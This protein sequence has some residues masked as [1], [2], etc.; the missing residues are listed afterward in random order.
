MLTKSATFKTFAKACYYS[1]V[2]KKNTIV[3]PVQIP[4]SVA[5]I[6]IL[7]FGALSFLSHSFWPGVET[8]GWGYIVLTGSFGLPLL[9]LSASPSG[10]RFGQYIGVLTGGIASTL[11]LLQTSMVEQIVKEL[12]AETAIS[13]QSAVAFLGVFI[14]SVTIPIAA[15]IVSRWSRLQKMVVCCLVC[16]AFAIA[17]QQLWFLLAKLSP[18]ATG[19]ELWTVA[20][21]LIH[22][23]TGAVFGLLLGAF[24]AYSTKEAS[25]RSGIF[26]FRSIRFRPGTIASAVVVLT[27]ASVLGIGRVSAQVA[28]RNRFASR[29]VDE[30]FLALSNVH[31]ARSQ[32]LL[33]QE[34]ETELNNA[35]TALANS[36]GFD[37][38]LRRLLSMVLPA[39]E[40]ESSGRKATAVFKKRV[41]ALNKYMAKEKIPFFFEPHEI[42]SITGKRRFLLRFKVEDVRYVTQGNRQV[43]M[44][45]MRRMDQILY[46]TPFAGLSYQG[47]GTIQMDHVDA[48]ALRFHARAFSYSNANGRNYARTHCSRSNDPFCETRGLMYGDMAQALKEGLAKKGIEDDAL[49]S[50]LAILSQKWKHRTDTG[51]AKTT[52]SPK[53]ADAYG[54][55]S[56]ILAAQTEI[57]EARHAFDINN[58]PPPEVFKELRTGILS[59][60]AVA[61]T[62]AHLSEIVDG[63]LGPHYAI[64]TLWNLVAG[65]EGV[66]ANAYFFSAI[67]IL[68]GLWEQKMRKPDTITVDSENGPTE[69]EMPISIEHPGWL[70]YSRICM[71]YHAL[72]TL[73][74][75][76]LKKRAKTLFEQMFNEPYAHLSHRKMTP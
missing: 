53:T 44:L 42:K 14:G 36:V 41:L 51:N 9:I 20:R 33:Y 11:M 75:E 17:G 70:S 1:W 6:P 23:T 62:R 69:K 28:D 8:S 19:A 12:D 34:L 63:P 73:S 15:L 24:Q 47:L 58:Y 60:S 56:E 25:V 32:G 10:G 72:R 50:Q 57:H 45:R 18:G 5:L 76:E 37:P 22:G 29:R 39:L 43:E 54:A 48:Q 61:E 64:A 71:C 55:L 16:A 2:K 49:L 38:T 40:D 35:R 31:L 26:S 4:V 46:D 30:Y 68:E 65:E 21:T 3:A 59:K 27:G 52:M 66:S 74:D 67:A 13:T 7:L